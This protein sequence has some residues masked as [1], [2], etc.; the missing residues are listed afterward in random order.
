[1]AVDA[2]VA[3]IQRTGD[4]DDGGFRKPET[5]QHVLGDFEDSLGG[6]NYGFVHGRTVRPAM[7]GSL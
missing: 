4:V 5:A 1:M 7:A 3:D 6:Q 2:A